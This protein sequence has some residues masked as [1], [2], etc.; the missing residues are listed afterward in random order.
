M[1]W[2][3]NG[4]TSTHALAS[5]HITAEVKGVQ[6]AEVSEVKGEVKGEVKCPL[7]AHKVLSMLLSIHL[8]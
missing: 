4:G 3:S 8:P 1:S 6:K 5:S 7:C 2:P